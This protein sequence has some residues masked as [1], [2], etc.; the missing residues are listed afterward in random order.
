MLFCHRQQRW[1]PEVHRYSRKTQGGERFNRKIFLM[2]N[3]P[4]DVRMVLEGLK[5]ALPDA[6]LSVAADG[7][8]A[9]R[10]LRRRGTHSRVPRPGLIFFDLLLSQKNGFD[11][12]CV[13]K[14]DA[15]LAIIPLWG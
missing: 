14:Q 6:R 9:I 7:V 10:F 3:N 4:A 8:E 2:E 15:T 1:P 11:V 5:E 13:K 12:L